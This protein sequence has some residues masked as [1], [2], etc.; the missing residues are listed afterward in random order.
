MRA[1]VISLFLHC[2]KTFFIEDTTVK[3]DDIALFDTIRHEPN[4]L[5][6]SRNDGDTVAVSLHILGQ[7]ILL[8]LASILENYWITNINPHLHTPAKP[9]RLDSFSSSPDTPLEYR[10]GREVNLYV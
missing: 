7:A 10:S 5:T 2:L 6:L 4:I 8:K 9:S 3:G 1:V